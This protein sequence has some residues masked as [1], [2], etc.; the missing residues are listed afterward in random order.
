[1][2]VIGNPLTYQAMLGLVKIENIKGS[3]E[4]NPMERMNALHR[5]RTGV[6]VPFD[7]Y[8]A[9]EVE[10]TK[11]VVKIFL[12]TSFDELIN[13]KRKFAVKHFTLLP[14]FLTGVNLDCLR[15]HFLNHLTGIKG[16]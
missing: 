16:G 10:D 7:C 11:T 3:T 15:S 13:Q 14:V 5:G 9:R 1:M 8:Y 2:L 12:C 6:S 4:K